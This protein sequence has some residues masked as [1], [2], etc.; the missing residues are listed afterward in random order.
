[1][2]EPR[3]GEVTAVFRF[4]QNRYL[5]L[6]LITIAFLFALQIINSKAVL[7]H[8][9]HAGPTK[10]L[11]QESDA[12]KT[13]LPEGGKIVKRKEAL[14]KE[15]YN[16]ALKRWGYS[17]DEGIYTYFISKDTEG[18]IS[19]TLFIQSVEYKH[20]NIEI[21]VGYN[22]TGQITDIKVLSCSEKYLKEV[23]E[24]I[25][26]GGFIEGFV[27]LKT[28]DVISKGKTYEKEDRE[29]LKYII[30]QKIEGTAI[31]LKLFQEK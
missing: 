22:K 12:L 29:S 28:D 15:K 14:K 17:P 21:A 3:S 18:N 2:S 9:G 6:S 24:N 25:Q 26:S 23:T 13:M 27:H 30:A 16:E 7:A 4:M 11:M 8:K 20:G 19:G 1:M 31:L 5:R 10:I